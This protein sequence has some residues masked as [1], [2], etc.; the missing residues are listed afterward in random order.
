[1]SKAV[2][3]LPTLSSYQWG[4]SGIDADREDESGQV[5]L[6]FDLLAGIDGQNTTISIK[7]VDF[8]VTIL[9]AN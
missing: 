1:M 5:E 7:E 9:A 8:Q 2:V 4:I 6:K 3:N